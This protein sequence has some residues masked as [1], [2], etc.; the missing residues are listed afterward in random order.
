MPI[1]D[2]DQSYRMNITNLDG[3]IEVLR[4]CFREL[5]ERIPQS[6]S[7]LSA[8]AAIKAAEIARARELRLDARADALEAREEAVGERERLADAAAVKSFCDGVAALAGRMDAF[9]RD[10]HE[11]ALAAEIAA[12]DEALRNL[13]DEGDLEPKE[14]PNLR[15][16][17][18][19]E[20][21]G[22]NSEAEG[23]IGKGDQDPAAVPRMP[24]RDP[25][26]HRL[27]LSSPG[28]LP[29]SL[30]MGDAADLRQFGRTFLCARD[31][32][33]WKRLMKR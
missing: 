27:P 11:Q 13:G 29:A 6:A 5:M 19:I 3:S 18:K 32:R 10:Q 9:E 7:R 2:P 15:D 23:A 25:E 12:A 26:P 22:G 16:A 31:R 4:G 33:A 30:V 20:A 28:G 17:D 14:A 24:E 1:I 21:L 8:E